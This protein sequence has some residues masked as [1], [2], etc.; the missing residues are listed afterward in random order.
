MNND[1][2]SHSAEPA[3]SEQFSEPEIPTVQT[4]KIG[5]KAFWLNHQEKN[6]RVNQKERADESTAKSEFRKKI[7]ETIQRGKDTSFLLTLDK[8]NS[9]EIEISPE[10]AIIFSNF[11]LTSPALRYNFAKTPSLR[12]SALG[13]EKQVDNTITIYQFTQKELHKINRRLVRNIIG[14]ISEETDNQSE[15][16]KQVSYFFKKQSQKF[17]SFFDPQAI[18]NKEK[19]KIVKK[20]ASLKNE[21]L[22]EYKGP[23]INIEEIIEKDYENIESYRQRID[24][25]AKEI[26]KQ[27]DPLNSSK[28]IISE[29]NAI[30]QAKNEELSRILNPE[31]TKIRQHEIAEKEEIFDHIFAARFP[32]YKQIVD[33]FYKTGTEKNL[34]EKEEKK[35]TLAFLRETFKNEKNLLSDEILDENEEK[36]KNSSSKDLLKWGKENFLKNKVRRREIKKGESYKIQTE[37]NKCFRWYKGHICKK[38]LES[39]P[40]YQ[41]YQNTFK[42][43]FD[44]DIRD[45]HNEEETFSL[46]R[47]FADNFNLDDET[48]HYFAEK[49]QKYYTL[50]AQDLPKIFYKE[51]QEKGPNESDKKSFND[52][53]NEKY[54][55]ERDKEIE[56]Y[57]RSHTPK[58]ILLEIA[59][60]VSSANEIEDAYFTPTGI[61]LKISG[62]MKFMS[63]SP[64]DPKL[65]RRIPSKYTE[66]WTN[67]WTRY[68]KS[69]QAEKKP[70]IFDAAARIGV[71]RKL[72]LYEIEKEKIDP[73]IQQRLS[74]ITQKMNLPSIFDKN[75][76]E[77][78][79]DIYESDLE[80]LELLPEQ[81]LNHIKGIKRNNIDINRL[82]V[83]QTQ[84]IIKNNLFYKPEKN[85]R[86]TRYRQA[87][88]FD[89]QIL[90]LEILKTIT[91]EDA[92]IVKNLILTDFCY[93]QYTANPDV[94]ST[95]QKLANNQTNF[96][97][98]SFYKLFG[99]TEP[100]TEKRK[101][102]VAKI[103]FIKELRNYFLNKPT[104][105]SN[106]FNE[107]YG[108]IDRSQENNPDNPHETNQISQILLDNN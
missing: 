49:Q 107:I 30:K 102:E 48:L 9:D 1:K 104:P 100:D 85:K 60:T 25:R 87:L 96:S 91:D 3:S 7:R 92:K 21:E 73:P 34:P 36:Y 42:A 55:P 14:K 50:Y 2:F 56:E 43:K 72:D 70:T 62:N 97:D 57:E 23:N 79:D 59:K 93:A 35:N 81:I 82:T 38:I 6:E 53:L 78:Y 65:I 69:Q 71:K 28:S 84:D 64:L 106:F 46:F 103:L 12:V 8:E 11:D 32:E 98:Y 31:S 89:N 54:Y 20:Y 29:E 17:E 45:F 86:E 77:I 39:N 27:N 4:K 101:E 19:E 90:K 13:L 66:V 41:K 5:K 37:I 74:E 51:I 18:N 26:L 80:S 99:Y 22:D 52:H 33:A 16:E 68:S 15:C 58:K 40:N 83:K 75:T 10:Q 108:K 61:L 76:G 105:Y 24:R 94:R 63:V 88:F 95:F 47:S 44:I 67:A